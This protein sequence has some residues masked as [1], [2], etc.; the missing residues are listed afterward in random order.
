MYVSILL[1]PIVVS[2]QNFPGGNPQEMQALMQKAQEV[3][4][5]MQKVDQ[6]KMQ[7]LQQ[8]VKQIGED[9]KTLCSAGKRDEAHSKAMSFSKEVLSNPIMQE[10][11]KCSEIMEGFMPDFSEIIQSSQDDGSGQHVCDK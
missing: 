8:R 9:V 3:Q 1:M 10:M 5:C 2:A 7:V 4:V 11:K 6:D